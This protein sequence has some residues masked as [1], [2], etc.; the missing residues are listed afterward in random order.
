[1]A[2]R[3]LA[4]R[5]EFHRLCGG[6]GNH[7]CD[8]YFRARFP[9]RYRLQNRL[10]YLL[11]P[12]RGF[13]L[14]RTESGELVCGRIAWRNQQLRT[15]RDARIDTLC[16]GLPSQPDLLLEALFDRSGGPLEFDEAVSLAAL[17]LGIRDQPLPLESIDRQAP[18]SGDT[19]AFDKHL[20]KSWEEICELS[21]PQRTALLLN[22]RGETEPSALALFP[23]TGIASVSDLA[24]VL[25]IPAIEFAEMWNRLPLGDGEI[26]QRLGLTRQQVIN[27]RLSAREAPRSPF[28]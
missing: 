2:L 25:E 28:K 22:L 1:M 27:L 6:D 8:D 20:R 14:W 10:R 26:A 12:A 18:S 3:W 17:A 21:L 13:D 24:A 23:L 7:A 15:V 16:S 5:I 9:A 11:K 4:T 19:G